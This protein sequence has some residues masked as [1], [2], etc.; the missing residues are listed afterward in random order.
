MPVVTLTQMF[1]NV[2]RV[3][4]L[5]SCQ[6]EVTELWLAAVMAVTDAGTCRV[7]S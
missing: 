1:K 3:H 4:T 6:S 2:V 5:T 7:G